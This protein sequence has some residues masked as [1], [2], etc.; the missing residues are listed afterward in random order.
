MAPLIQSP[1]YL[2]NCLHFLRHVTT[3]PDPEPAST[4]TPSPL[5][6]VIVG[7]GLGGLAAAIAFARKKNT[8]TI[9]E[10]AHQ[11]AEVGAGIQ[12]PPNSTRLLLKLGLGPY[13][14]KY[15]TEPESVL[16]RR[17]EDGKVIGCTRLNPEF[18]EQ[19]DAPY[20]VIHR[21]HFHEAMHDL[22]TDLGVVVH[23]SSR[24]IAYDAHTPSLTLEDGLHVSAD[25]VVAADGVNSTA[26]EV[27]L[28]G[29]SSPPQRTGFAAYR[30]VVDIDRMRAE[31]ELSWL[32]E[33]PSFNLWLGDNR[34]VMTY[35]I[36]AGKSFNMV[37]SHPDDSDVSGW[38][39]DK[40]TNLANMR[41][42]FE[43]WDP[44]LLKIIQMIDK[45]LKWPLLSGSIMDRWV[46]GKL[47]V[48]GDAAHAMLPYM[49]QGAAIA[50]EDGVALAHCI[51]KVEAKSQIQNAL[52]LF[53]N[54]RQERA[55][56]M[57]QAS[58][59]NGKLWHFPDGPLQHARDAAMQP[60]VE[61][62]PFSHSPNQWS[63]PA[64]QMWCYAYDAER[65]IDKE[66]DKLRGAHM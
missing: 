47:V 35:V 18:R 56:L 37:L 23:L 38:N 53:A 13:L 64:T 39:Q 34:H 52:N 55:G 40:D 66:W 59:L 29:T 9:Y 2:S 5:N 7:A 45:A 11:L 49:S 19:F 36:G 51:S 14:E 63:D 31:P 48:L 42:E 4:S 25:L 24:V 62:R 58:L 16:M 15:V 21:A 46:L 30:A 50:V 8:V 61:G 22:A 17:W 60:E 6:V 26:R 10:Q 20:W 41:K 28:G 57:Q 27:V 65:E 33:K 1:R 43:G 54:V 32:L 44:I 3:A 12:I